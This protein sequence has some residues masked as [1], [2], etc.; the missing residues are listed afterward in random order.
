MLVHTQPPPC[1]TRKLKNVWAPNFISNTSVLWIWWQ[2]VTTF[3]EW[4]YFVYVLIYIVSDVHVYIKFISGWSHD[5]NYGRALWLL[6]SSFALILVWCVCP[7][8]QLPSQQPGQTARSEIHGGSAHQHHFLQNEG[9]VPRHC[10]LYF[11]THWREASGPRV[12]VKGAFILGI[13][14]QGLPLT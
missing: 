14:S 6:S 4:V 9:N 5:L 3:E 7:T 13:T 12:S 2:V 11:T 1:Y 10:T 8:E